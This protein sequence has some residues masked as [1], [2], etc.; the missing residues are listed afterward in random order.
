M[1][2]I[3]HGSQYLVVHL[4]CSQISK[5]EISYFVKCFINLYHT[6]EFTTLKGHF[7]LPCFHQRKVQMLKTSAGLTEYYF[8]LSGREKVC[9]GQMVLKKLCLRFCFLMLF[10]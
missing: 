6:E 5:R 4:T 8:Y 7:Y 2:R 9:V 10:L 3:R 1:S